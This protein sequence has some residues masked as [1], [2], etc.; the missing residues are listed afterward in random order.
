MHGRERKGK[1]EGGSAGCSSCV[2]LQSVGGLTRDEV[3]G[4]LR[5]IN[6]RNHLHHLLYLY[7]CR[8]LADELGVPVEWPLQHEGGVQ[9]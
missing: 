8:I 1:R 6:M 9:C 7:A 2:G 3:E 4:I 5:P